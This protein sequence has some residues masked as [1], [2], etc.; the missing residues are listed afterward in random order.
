MAGIESL[1]GFLS[2]VEVNTIASEKSEE[3]QQNPEDIQEEC[4][5]L[6][7]PEGYESHLDIEAKQTFIISV[8]AYLRLYSGTAGPKLTVERCV[9]E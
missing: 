9:W 3:G 7:G 6:C 5:R 8:D 4:M 2:R 1:A